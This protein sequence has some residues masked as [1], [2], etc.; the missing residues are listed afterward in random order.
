MNNMGYEKDRSDEKAELYLMSKSDLTIVFSRVE[1][2]YIRQMDHDIRV[3]VFPF[4]A[5]IQGRGH[6]LDDRKDLM[7]MRGFTKSIF[8]RPESRMSRAIR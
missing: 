4:V 1:E 8:N 3:E 6:T 2:E 7:D 5:A